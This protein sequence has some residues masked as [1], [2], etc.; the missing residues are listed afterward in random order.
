MDTLYSLFEVIRTFPA[1]EG[2]YA[3]PGSPARSRH[4]AHA[5]IY[6]ARGLSRQTEDGLTD[7]SFAVR[8]P[9]IST[10]LSTVRERA[11]CL[12]TTLLPRVADSREYLLSLS[13]RR[14]PSL[15]MTVR[16]EIAEL[17]SETGAWSREGGRRTLCSTLTD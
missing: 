3:T 14:K 8:D 6:F 9:V 5:A 7:P 13:S 15:F 2:R 12:T 4:G 10:G 17:R 11:G 16:R 1:H